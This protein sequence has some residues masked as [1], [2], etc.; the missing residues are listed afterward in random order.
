GTLKLLSEILGNLGI[1]ITLLPFAA[2]SRFP[3]FISPRTRLVVL[4]S[5]TNPTL[6][7]VDLQS[8]C[9]HAHQHNTTILVDNTFA[10]PILQSPLA[11]G[12]DLVMHSATKYLGGH[13]D[14]SAGALCGA[15]PIIDRC[16]HIN[17][18]TGGTLDPHASFLLIRGMKTLAIR[19]ERVCDNATRLAHAL[20]HHP[21]VAS[22][23]YPGNDPVAEK[24]MKRPGAMLSI[25]LRGGASA[26]EKLLTSTRLWTLAPSLGGVESTLSY[27]VLASHAGL[28]SQWEALGITPALVRLSVGIE[29]YEDLLADLEQA[30]VA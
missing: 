28:E 16:R 20:A 1:N 25:E 7:C 4:E 11:Y 5:P 6:R 27:P 26:A 23:F 10:T 15:K 21:A 14:L 9:T 17:V 22:V 2:I 12:A 19:V 24:Q 3:E 29:A 13:S 8:L 18:L 30:L